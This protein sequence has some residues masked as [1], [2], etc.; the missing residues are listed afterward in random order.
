MLV[1]KDRTRKVLIPIFFVLFLVLA[2]I[3]RLGSHMMLLLDDLS[4]VVTQEYTPRILMFFSTIGGLLA[5]YPVVIIVTLLVASFLYLVRFQ[6]AAMWF[7]LMQSLLLP[8]VMLLTVIINV[9]WDN[10]LQIGDTIP[11]LLV[12]WWFEIFS[13][14]FTL[15]FPKMVRSQS[16][17][18]IVM[19]VMFLIWIG[20]LLAQLQRGIALSTLVGAMLFGYFW[21]QLS[22]QLYLKLAKK[23]QIIFSL[24]GRL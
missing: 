1:S 2:L 5:H 20:I 10:G 24:G 11:N 21:W 17:Q 23:G 22:Q 7:L 8:I 4:G 16:A 13:V 3:V 15:I 18:Y 9:H 19:G 12:T 6:V 14:F